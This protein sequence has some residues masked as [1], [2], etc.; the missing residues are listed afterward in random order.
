MWNY[1]RM[2]GFDPEHSCDFPEDFPMPTDKSNSG[3]LTSFSNSYMNPF[4][5]DSVKEHFLWHQRGGQP[6]TPIK[7][8][9]GVSHF[10]KIAY[11]LTRETSHT[12]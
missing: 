1:D 11:H 12:E 5:V 4:S 10:L 6:F 3:R 9:E 7:H 8:L 2:K